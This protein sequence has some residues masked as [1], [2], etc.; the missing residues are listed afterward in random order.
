M[1]EKWEEEL[2]A[3][4][5]SKQVARE[6][7]LLEVEEPIGSETLDYDPDEAIIDYII[8]A[9]ERKRVQEE[10]RTFY[11]SLGENLFRILEERCQSI[12]VAVARR[13][14]LC[15]LFKHDERKLK[16]IGVWS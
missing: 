1:P 5:R 3:L 8:S 14:G 6:D 10:T 15:I 9:A 11:F 16:F 7:D 12:L 2:E 13:T 4:L